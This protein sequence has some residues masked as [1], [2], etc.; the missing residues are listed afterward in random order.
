LGARI[1]AQFV[2]VLLAPEVDDAALEALREKPATRVLG[3]RE[4]RGGDPGERDYR[5]VLGGLLVQDRDSD[6]DDREGMHVVCGSPSETVW[7]DLLFAWRAC[8]H[9]TSN[10]IVIV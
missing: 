9:V 5:R 3:D 4:R 7:G 1:A 10:A 2:E 8:K 6:V